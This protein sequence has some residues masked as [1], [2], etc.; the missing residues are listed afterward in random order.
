MG[1]SLA[2][3]LKA[4]AA[5]LGKVYNQGGSTGGIFV[6][7]QVRRCYFRSNLNYCGCY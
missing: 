7:A 1:S 6:V 5:K 2:E 4:R 3:E